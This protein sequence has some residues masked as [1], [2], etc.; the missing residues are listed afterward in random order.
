M[1]SQLKNF[2]IYTI[3]N[4]LKTYVRKTKENKMCNSKIKN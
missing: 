3:N 2:T 4:A 1:L